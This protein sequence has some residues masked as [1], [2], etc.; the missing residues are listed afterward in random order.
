MTIS[1]PRRHRGVVLTLT[2]FAKLA[3]AKS[4]L[5]IAEN[6]GDSE[7]LLLS[8]DRITF[9]AWGERTELN[10]R[11]IARI[12]G[13]TEGVDK[14][15]L[16]QLFRVLNLKLEKGDYTEAKPQR[17]NSTGE[18]V[19]TRIDWGE[20]VDVPVFYDRTAELVQLEY[21]ILVEGTRLLAI[22]GM[23]GIGKTALAVKLAEQINC[24]FE[25][26][27]WRSLRN[28]PP[29]Q[30]IVADLL[31]FL[32]P[33][34]PLDLSQSLNTQINQFVKCLHSARCL[35][36]LDNAESILGDGNYTGSYREGCE[37]YGELLRRVGE[38]RHTSC[39]VIT[40]REK[41]R[42]VAQLEGKN[43]AVR[44]LELGGLPLDAGQKIFQEQGKFTATPQQWQQAIGHY[45]GNPLALKLVAVGVQEYLGGSISALL[46]Y[47]GQGILVFDDIRDLLERQFSR[48]TEL[49]TQVMYWLAV[50][51][52][53]VTLQELQTH[54]VTLVSPA[55]LL[56]AVQSLRRRCLIEK[57]GTGFT[58][59][60]VVMEFALDR[61]VEGVLKEIVQHNPEQGYCPTPLLRSISLL[62]VQGKDYLLTSQR[63]LI[64]TPLVRGLEAQLGSP[65]RI[66]QRLREMLVTLQ[67]Q[68]PLERGY[69]AGNILNLLVHMGVDLRAWDFS[70]LS[71]WQADLRNMDLPQV[72]F[73]RADLRQSVFTEIFDGIHAVAFS[74]DGKLLATGDMQG[75][76]HVYQVAD[77]KQQLTLRGHRNWIAS[78]AFSLDGQ[79]LCSSSKD[80]T[81]YVWDVR[82][83]QA[84]TTWIEYD[85]TIASVGLSPDGQTL[86]SGSWDGTVKLWS[87]NTGNCEKTLLGHKSFVRV[88]MFS[89]DGQMLASSSGDRT[90]RLWDVSTGHTT[91]ILHHD[92]QLWSIAFSPDGQI[93]AGSGAG[94]TIKL[95][96]VTTGQVNQ[97]LTGHDLMIS[98]AFSPSGQTLVSGSWDGKLKLWDVTTGQCRQTWQ[99]HKNLV[100]AIAFSPDGKVL[101]SGSI[102]QALKLWDSTTGQCL[103]TLQGYR[104]RIWSLTYSPNGQMLASGSHDHTVKL[105]DVTTGQLKRTLRGHTKTVRSVCWSPDGL[106]LA[107]GSDDGTIK[108][109]EV[110]TGT[111]RQTWK[112]HN[113]WVWS[114]CWSPDGQTL[115]SGSCDQTLKLW[116]VR[117]GQCQKILGAP[118]HGVLSV[119]FRPNGKILASGSNDGTVKLW[120]VGTGQVK[121]TLQGHTAWVWSLRW[122]PDGCTLATGSV[123]QTVKVWDISTGQCQKTL[124]GHKASVWSVV[125]SPD[126]QTLVSG[127]S[128]CLLKFWD[129][130]TG[131]CQQTLQGHSHEVLSVTFSPDGQTIASSSG[132]ETIKLWDASTGKCLKTLKCEKPYE[133]M[134]ICGVTGLTEVTL[135]TL[136]ALGAIEDGDSVRADVA[137]QLS[138]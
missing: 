52:E 118:N 135:V 127:S 14:R 109:W 48:L 16:V 86:A 7:A 19:D 100:L 67:E 42:V 97:T 46:D 120:D 79:T 53:A 77:L 134:N 112:G 23:G 116:D 99:A 71:V 13:C 98:V 8:A 129:I 31:Q 41:P 138:A 106:V 130:T 54:A 94:T 62:I 75:E 44:S 125:F 5:E 15:S 105:W 89:P 50:H 59:Q 47:M 70:D 90:V 29:V 128:D 6:F 72:N 43:R 104:N 73:A 37:G 49:E 51:R 107:S 76:V 85:R 88:V 111:C 24:H 87:V 26:V 4:Q 126:G 133:G 34:Q 38:T 91:K 69:T 103:R 74:P 131:Q 96:D 3:A 93:L 95:W 12:F 119:A 65:F 92:D 102:D 30:E 60:P 117:T 36:V 58:L 122:S 124:N 17:D 57:S 10:S 83:G 1:K 115:V 81:M 33:E 68:M 84:L 123:D 78:V 56:S 9:E 25:S 137:K 21:A 136:K 28:A 35:I 45:A 61:L 108:L 40:S 114:L 32:C 20:V 11:T 22:L 80:G 132:D 113:G 55:S 82:T 64:L 2:G 110:T 66:E 63:R 101:A 18:I 39:V 27:I 121:S